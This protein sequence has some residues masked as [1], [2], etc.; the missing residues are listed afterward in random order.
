MGK[1]GKGVAKLPG[2]TR[3]ER[4]LTSDKEDIYF[5]D[6]ASDAIMQHANY[7][8]DGKIEVHFG[9]TENVRRRIPMTP[10]IPRNAAFKT[11]SQ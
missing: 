7:A 6:T 2:E 11:G 3:R 1:G 9:K 4:V 8:S 5:R 10:R